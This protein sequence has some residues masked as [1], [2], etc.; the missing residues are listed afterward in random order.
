[1]DTAVWAANRI[2]DM[3]DGPSS[4]KQFVVSVLTAETVTVVM[5][6]LGAWRS[7]ASEQ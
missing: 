6:S 7:T 4:S 3:T 2:K 5:T 1:M